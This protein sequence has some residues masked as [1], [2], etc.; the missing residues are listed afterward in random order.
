MKRLA[1]ILAAL[2]LSTALAQSAPPT[3]TLYGTPGA[4]CATAT[5]A[6]SLVSDPPGTLER[7]EPGAMTLC[8]PAVPSWVEASGPGGTVRWEQG[9]PPPT[10]QPEPTPLAPQARCVPGTRADGEYDLRRWIDDGT[11]YGRYE[12]LPC[13][14]PPPTPE[15]GP[16]LTPRVWL[17]VV[18]RA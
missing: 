2:A 7:L 4:T 13:T 12:I 15:P 5:D 17:G 8:W 18:M 3:L 11:P 9:A 6:T 16:P 1:A 10:T 14:A